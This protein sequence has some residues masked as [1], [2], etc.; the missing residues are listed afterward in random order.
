MTAEQQG[1]RAEAMQEGQ[2]GG[3]KGKLAVDPQD[4]IDL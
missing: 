4:T 3:A 2:R 1:A